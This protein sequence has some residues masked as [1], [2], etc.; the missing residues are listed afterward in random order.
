M[1]QHPACTNK[2]R[3][4]E[5]QAVRSL[6][7]SPTACAQACPQLQAAGPGRLLC[8]RVSGLLHGWA[9][10][11]RLLWMVVHSAHE[12][13]PPFLECSWEHR[14]WPCVSHTQHLKSR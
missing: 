2:K 1:V 14:L 10:T 5:I 13:K 11:Q 6:P 3:E 7:N 4:D 9:P 12:H 8:S